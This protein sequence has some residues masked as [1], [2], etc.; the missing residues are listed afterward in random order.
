[1]SDLLHES[2]YDSVLGLLLFVLYIDYIKSVIQNIYCHLYED[3]DHWLS[4]NKMT[5]NTKKKKRFGNKAHLKKLENRTVRYLNTPAGRSV[6]EV[7][8]LRPFSKIFD[9][10]I[11]FVVLNLIIKIFLGQFS[12]IIRTLQGA[13]RTGLCDI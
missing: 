8:N 5:I 3:V 6:F 13:S 1:M 10:V 9:R 7:G 4:I 11:I 2:V 12:L